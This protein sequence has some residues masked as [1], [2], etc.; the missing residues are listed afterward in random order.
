MV[1]GLVTQ[2]A[3][4]VVSNKDIQNSNPSSPNYKISKKEKNGIKSHPNPLDKYFV[5]LEKK[6]KKLPIMSKSIDGILEAESLTLRKFSAVH[7]NNHSH[8]KRHSN[9]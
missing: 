3:L 9:V 4:S 1:M 8:R 7:G 6:K 2:L 5:K